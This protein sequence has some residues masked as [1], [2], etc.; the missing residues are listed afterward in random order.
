MACS[1]SCKARITSGNNLPGLASSLESSSLLITRS[2]S[3]G[4]ISLASKT[5]LSSCAIKPVSL[6]PTLPPSR[7]FQAK[8]TGLT[9]LK[10]SMPVLRVAMS[11]LS[12]ASLSAVIV[13]TWARMAVMAA[14]PKVIVLL[15]VADRAWALQPKIML[16][17]PVVVVQPA[18]A[19]IKKL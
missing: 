18:Q 10:K 9:C 5:D 16:F 15:V 13:V 1:S 11:H 7:M 17:E 4:L 12:L 2:D 6:M 14:L 19:P 3:Q 8:V